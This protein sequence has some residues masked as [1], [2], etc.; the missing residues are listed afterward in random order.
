MKK[1][2]VCLMSASLLFS[3][4]KEKEQAVPTETIHICG[5]VT[6]PALNIRY[7]CYWKNGSATPLS[8]TTATGSDGGAIDM[9]V[10]NNDVYIV[11]AEEDPSGRGIG[12]YW[13]NG[14]IAA[15]FD[16]GTNNL[17]CAAIAVNAG[18]VHIA[19][20]Q[21]SASGTTYTPKYWKDGTMTTLMV[22][23]AVPNAFLSDIVTSGNDVYIVGS[24][25][26]GA[27]RN[28]ILWKNGSATI[29]PLTNT[30]NASGF[31]MAVSGND[32]YIV[33]NEYP[34]GGSVSRIMLYKNNEAPKVITETTP[35]GAKDV[36]V[37]NTDLYI[38]GFQF[39]ANATLVAN[40]WKNGTK[41]TLESGSATPDSELTDIYIKNADVFTSG[42]TYVN[43]VAA[44][45][46]WKN[47]VAT[48][49]NN[50]TFSSYP[51]KIIV[52]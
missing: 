9:A 25:V 28:C 23:G 45:T 31:R 46:Y 52:Q 6:D 41:V 2:T 12:R 43:N 17:S 10:Y 15:S 47:G 24:Q 19:V 7:A 20:N 11:G 1:I 51:T 8:S 37:S 4:K 14:T 26:S 39:D 30:I 13:K 50:G 18:G 35:A 42:I 32:V 34:V 36:F 40:Y 44:V 5:S 48:R 29:I 27:N 16:D 3:C 21:Q 22:A 33:T 38:A 49:L